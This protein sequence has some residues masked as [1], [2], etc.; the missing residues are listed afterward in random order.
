MMAQQE[1]P[2]VTAIAQRLTFHFRSS[3]FA[4]CDVKT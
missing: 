1:L 2:T 3:L 4:A